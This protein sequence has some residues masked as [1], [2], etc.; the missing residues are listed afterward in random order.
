MF[1][2]GRMETVGRAK[3]DENGGRLSTSVLLVWKRD[4]KE[5]RTSR[6]EGAKSMAFDRPC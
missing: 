6:T 4:G 2:D 1:I 3:C 5:E